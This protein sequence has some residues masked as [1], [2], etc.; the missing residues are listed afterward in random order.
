MSELAKVYS[1]KEVESKWYRHWEQSGFFHAEANAKRKPYTIVIPPPNITGV[2][3]MGHILNNTL[4]DAFIRY[5]RMRGFEACW[6][7][8]TDHAGIATQNVVEKALKKENKTRHDL[9]REEFLER[10]SQWKEQYGGTIIKQLRTL[11]CSCDWDRERFTMDENLSAA[12]REVFVRMFEE[13][14]IYRGKYIVNWCPKDHTAISDDE[15]NHAEQQGKIYYIKYPIKGTLVDDPTRRSKTRLVEEFAVVAT[16]RP[17]TMLGDVA[18]AVNPNDDRYKHLV[19][20]MVE[21]PLTGRDIPIIADEYVDATF[22]SGMV[23]ITPAHD[24]ND[25]WVGQR[26]TLPQIN[27]FDIS[28]KLNENAPLKY[29]GM[30]RSDARKVIV[31]DLAAAN[32]IEKIEDYTNNVGR[33]Y[34]CD[35]IIEPYLSDQWF[36]KMKPLAEPALKV[37]LDGT[38]RF[39]PDRWKKVYEHWM[40]NIRDWCISRQL[41]WGHRIPVWYCVGDE[42]CLLECKQPIVSRTAPEKCPHC[43]STNLRQDED[44]LDTWFS[45]WLWPFSVHDWPQQERL[46]KADDLAYFYP[47]DTLVTAPDIIFFWVARMIMAGVHF[48]PSFTGST[49]LEKNVPFKDVYFTSLVRDAQGRKMSKSLGNSPEPIDLITEYGADAVRFTILYLAP[50]GQDILYSKEKNELGRNFANKI[51]NAGRFLLMNRGSLGEAPT[52]DLGRKFSEFH[53]D[54]LDLADKWI[55][56]RLHSTTMELHKA[57]DEF[58]INKVTKDIYDFFWHDYCDWYVEMIKSRLYGDE[59]AEV[60][61]AVVARAVDIYDA[62]LRML[63]PLMPFVTEELWQAIRER[64]HDETIMRAPMREPDEGFINKQVEDEMLFVQNVIESLRN[65]R[66]EMSIAPPKEISLVVKLSGNRTAKSVEKYSGYLQRLAKVTSLT[67]LHDSPRPKLSASAVVQGEELFIPLE[68]LIDIEVEKARVK[69][70]IA[71]VSG[72]LGGVQS[73]LANAGFV[74][75]APKEVVEKEREKLSNFSQ[76]LEKLERNYSALN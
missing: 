65:I 20:T 42:R 45:S 32:L 64:R 70:E 41:W 15:V 17:E 54:H 59:P 24:P 28:A 29:R 46:G 49:A 50:L 69:K 66:G 38:I 71:R 6:V 12:V 74:D 40:T 3:H 19:G 16:T 10:V 35:T 18:V 55:L 36:V 62:A 44:V 73:K 4:Q 5:K 22:G 8:G 68:G 57:M 14:L 60:K 76:T 33:C 25:Y 30:D 11:G 23:K 48:G 51:W 9:G 56:S 67:F 37:V 72:L 34:R 13:G 53:L 63:H 31:E 39:Y 2:L 1:P 43:G 61:Q 27:V 58:E 52:Y 7:P 47:T 26:H 75:K 21:L